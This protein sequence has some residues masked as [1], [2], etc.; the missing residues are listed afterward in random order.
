MRTSFDSSV[1]PSF[2]RHFSD[3]SP[4]FFHLA[5]ALTSTHTTGS[6]TIFFLSPSLLNSKS[7]VKLQLFRTYTQ[8]S[9]FWPLF[10]LYFR[11]ILIFFSQFPP[12]GKSSIAAGSIFQASF[13]FSLILLDAG[14]VF[15]CSKRQNFN[16]TYKMLLFILEKITKFSLTAS[17]NNPNWTHCTVIQRLT[18]P[19]RNKT[20]G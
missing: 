14:R 16:R 18:V 11:T 17:D 19:P 1:L 5:F 3:F 4:L 6:S 8:H 12:N 20:I 13:L 9:D 15:L 2:G 10:S 7:P